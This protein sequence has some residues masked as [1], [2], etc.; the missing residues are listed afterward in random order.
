MGD[1]AA[2]RAAGQSLR[3]GVLLLCLGCALALAPTA[4]AGAPGAS[5]S[6][7]DAPATERVTSPAETRVTPTETPVS[8]TDVAA[9]VDPCGGVERPAVVATTGPDAPAG[10]GDAVGAYRGTD[11]VLALCAESGGSHSFHGDAPDGLEVVEHA[12]EAARVRVLADTNASLGSLV[13]PEPVPGPRVALRG[14]R[15]QTSL[16][17]EPLAVGSADRAAGVVAAEATYRDRTAAYRARLDDLAN[18]TAA[19]E[20]GDGPDAETLNDTLAARAAY[21]SALSTY[22]GELYAVADDGSR[23]A[24]AALL[25]LES[26]HETLESTAADRL[27]AYDAALVERE[28]SLTWAL[29]L[30]VVGLGLVGLLVGA[31]AGATLPVRR[32][33]R[34]RRRLA[35]GDWTTYS[36]RAAL[37][38]VAVGGALLLAGLALLLVTAGPTLLEVLG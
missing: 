9:T 37:A 2:R 27:G 5:L 26:R 12:S 19:I 6:A 10:P 17:E 28:R 7:V 18:A 34:A 22:R 36:R 29:R 16:L 31:A 21:R 11:L 3:A 13:D 25:A 32:G 1:P 14:E 23:D 8:F 33:R 30:R 24:G 20:D 35:R 38:P 15:V 4:L